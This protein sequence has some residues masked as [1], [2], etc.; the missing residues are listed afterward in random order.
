[1]LGTAKGRRVRLLGC[2]ALFLCC[3][4][5]HGQTYD[6]SAIEK[7]ENHSRLGVEHYQAGRYAEAIREMLA[8]YQAVPDAALHYN[9]ARIYQA[10]SYRHLTL[11]TIYSV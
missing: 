7:A 11:P 5:A 9:V 1:M 10:V 6:E 3:R 8:A 4:L 2:I